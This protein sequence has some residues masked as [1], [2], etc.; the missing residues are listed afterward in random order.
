MEDHAIAYIP[1]TSRGGHISG[2]VI[3]ATICAP[4]VR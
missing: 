2:I 1:S 4:C 3:G